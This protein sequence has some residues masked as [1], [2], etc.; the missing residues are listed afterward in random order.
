MLSKLL[1]MCC[2]VSILISDV[3]CLCNE[4]QSCVSEDGKHGYCMGGQCLAEVQSRSR[5]DLEFRII[6]KYPEIN[7]KEIQN[8]FLY[9]RGSG[10]GLNWTAGKKMTK[11]ASD[12]WEILFTF[13]SSDDG[14]RCQDCSSDIKIT[15]KLEYRILIADKTNMIGGNFVVDLPVSMS[16]SYFHEKPLIK[17]YPWFYSKAGHTSNFTIN[18][19]EI[20]KERKI[21]LYFPPSFHENTYK[22]Y[23]NLLVFDLYPGGD[24]KILTPIV[25]KLLAETGTTKEFIIIGYGDYQ[26]IH[27]RFVLL[28]PVPGT[29]LTCANGTFFNLCDNCLPKNY[30]VDEEYL[31]LMIEKCGKRDNIQGLGDRLLDFVLHKVRPKAQELANKR[32]LIDQ[33]N[34]GIM[35]YSLGGLMSCY[36][37]WT[38]SAIFGL[39]AC[40]SP[41]LWWPINNTTLN[42][43]DFDFINN[44]LRDKSFQQ[45]RFPQK[46]VLDAGSEET[47]SPYKL[48]QSTVETAK[49]ISNT[50]GFTMNH[51][52]W[53]NIYPGETHT[54][55]SWFSRFWT[56][57]QTLLPSEGAPQMPRIHTD[58]SGVVA[59]SA[60]S[61]LYINFTLLICVQCA[62]FL[63]YKEV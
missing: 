58:P 17:V 4:T 10:L 54:V 33:P 29:Y 9:I 63:F 40:Q 5:T 22:K 50:P 7:I 42:T 55:L 19:T 56:V 35:G 59:N 34:T 20:G 41:S 2:F 36:A 57:C 52:V 51:N 3:D 31:R 60:S 28:T 27:E 32:I 14:F 18:S 43:S 53:V 6:A 37:A 45:R 24:S 12:T 38:R 44:T 15:K 25:D 46:I 21:Y 49:R 48:T 16:S 26:P 8:K 23:P 11:T 62:R 30:T 61:Y 1:L 47:V 13:T 39:A